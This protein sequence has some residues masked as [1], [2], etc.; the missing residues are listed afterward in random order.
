MVTR[1]QTEYRKGEGEMKRAS[2]NTGV[3][4]QTHSNYTTWM[5]KHSGRHV[6]KDRDIV[7]PL[8]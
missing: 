8:W 1:N 5:S 7:T 4:R 3:G 6:G 2:T